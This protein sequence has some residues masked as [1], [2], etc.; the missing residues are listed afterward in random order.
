MD[1]SAPFASAVTWEKEPLGQF[2]LWAWWFDFWTNLWQPRG[3]FASM[4]AP[5]EVVPSNIWFRRVLLLE[6]SIMWEVKHLQSQWGFHNGKA[7]FLV[8]WWKLKSMATEDFPAAKSTALRRRFCDTTNPTMHD[9][10]GLNVLHTFKNR[11]IHISTNLHQWIFRSTNK[12]NKGIQLLFS[13]WKGFQ[14]SRGHS[15]TNSLWE[16]G[17]QK[18]SEPR[19]LGLRG[20]SKIILPLTMAILSCMKHV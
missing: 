13:Y 16:A 3:S 4:D 17:S 12:D 6:V 7:S 10:T 19:S 8:R 9:S 2:L 20:G 18:S 5:I 1:P 11:Q 15:P 14:G